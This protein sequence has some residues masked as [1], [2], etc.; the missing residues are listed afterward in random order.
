[1]I[2]LPKH[3]PRN[4]IRSILKKNFENNFEMVSYFL[5]LHCVAYNWKRVNILTAIFT[6]IL[7]FL[8]KTML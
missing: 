2:L 7:M 4:I 6:Y 3:K 5:Q 1:M 8:S